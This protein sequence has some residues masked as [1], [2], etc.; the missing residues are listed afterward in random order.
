MPGQRLTGR[1]CRRLE[2]ML[3]P[4]VRGGLLAA[5]DGSVDPRLLARALLAAAATGGSAGHPAAGDRGSTAV[6]ARPG[7]RT[8]SRGGRVVLAAGWNSVHH[9]RAAARGG[10]AGP[11]GQGPD[12]AAAHGRPARRIPEP[13]ACAAWSAAPRSTWY[14]GRTASWWSGPPRR[15]W[16][17]TP[18]S[19]PGGLWELLRD[20]RALVPGITEL[21]FAEAVAGLRPGTPDNA[22]VLGP[23]RGRRPGPGHRALPDR[24]A[25]HPDHRRRHRGYLADRALARGARR[26][27]HP[28]SGSAT[29]GRARD[30]QQAAGR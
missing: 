19:P 28:S 25:A 27:L 4:S 11:A 29:R 15:S 6:T 16:A 26:A 30:L 8:A 21:E 24:R 10:A 3:D 14:R 5:A 20:A 2:P 1:E 18:G 22:P 12:P 13:V 17:S 23:C 7:G 9:R